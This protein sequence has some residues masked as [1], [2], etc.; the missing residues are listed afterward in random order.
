VRISFGSVSEVSVHP[1]LAVLLLRSCVVKAE[2][3]G[4]EAYDRAK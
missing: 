3:H 4:G 2:H 1:H